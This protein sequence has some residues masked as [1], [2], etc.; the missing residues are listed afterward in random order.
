MQW[1]YSGKQ[2]LSCISNAGGTEETGD[3]IGAQWAQSYP[4]YQF[5]P[6][7]SWSQKEYR[8]DARNDSQGRGKNAFSSL[9]FWHL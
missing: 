2:K 3:V 4:K 7:D 8:T 1:F 6:V 9:F 5:F